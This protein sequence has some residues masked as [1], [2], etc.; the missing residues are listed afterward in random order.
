MAVDY[1]SCFFRHVQWFAVTCIGIL[2]MMQKMKLIF[3]LCV[4]IAQAEIL[5]VLSHRNII[6]FYGAIIEAPHY[7]IVTGKLK[8]KTKQMI[9]QSCWHDAVHGAVGRLGHI[10]SENC[11]S[12]MCL[13]Q[14][15]SVFTRERCRGFYGSIGELRRVQ[16]VHT[17]KQ[18]LCVFCLI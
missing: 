12:W 10:M 4:F 2:I 8:N 16:E 13:H 14:L 3:S 17:L 6:Q 18:Q 7:G 9:N 1:Q 11:S 15:H 5:S